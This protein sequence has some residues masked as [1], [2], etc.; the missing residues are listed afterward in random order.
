M[1]KKAGMYNG[2][3]IASSIKSLG[4]LDSHMQ[5]NQT[6]TFSHHIKNHNM[7]LKNLK[8]KTWKP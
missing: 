6:I 1:I 5:T 4:K 7:D 2:E 3:K 8:C